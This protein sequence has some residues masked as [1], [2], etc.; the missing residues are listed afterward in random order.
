MEIILFIS[1]LML[2]YLMRFVFDNSFS[3]AQRISWAIMAGLY[4]ANSV[5]FLLQ[6]I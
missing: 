4:V 5:Y 1:N 3:A 2:S 6:I